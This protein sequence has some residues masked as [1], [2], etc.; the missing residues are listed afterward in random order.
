MRAS[1]HSSASSPAVRGNAIIEFA[2]AFGLLWA[3]LAGVFQFGYAMYIYNELAIAAANGARFASRVDFDS[4]AQS[5]VGRV[6]NIVVYGSPG[7]GSTPLVT[8]LDTTKVSVTWNADSAGVPQTISVAIVNYTCD[9][10]FRTFTWNNKPSS[11]VRFVGVYK[12]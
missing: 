6:Q 4:V 2:L 12:N 9:A 3:A 8:G 5:F 10:V 1:A 11:T 7:G